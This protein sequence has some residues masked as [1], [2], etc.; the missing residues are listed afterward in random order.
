MPVQVCGG[1][2][3]PVSS[4]QQPPP[5]LLG[6]SD[7]ASL[8]G[9]PAGVIVTSGCYGRGNGGNG[10]GNGGHDGGGGHGC[11]SQEGNGGGSAHT[12]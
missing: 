1:D 8:A 9:D 3:G 4:P 5:E 2:L 6:G 7:G 12:S 10:G 11:N